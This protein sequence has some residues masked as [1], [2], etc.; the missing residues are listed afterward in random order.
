[1]SEYLPW[2]LAVI[3]IVILAVLIWKR[4]SS[5]TPEGAPKE[6]GADMIVN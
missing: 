4:S 3:P 1:M 5:D 6:Y 2:G